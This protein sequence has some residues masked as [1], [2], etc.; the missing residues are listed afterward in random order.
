GKVVPVL[1]TS[2]GHEAT[3]AA[4]LDFLTEFAPSADAPVGFEA[5]DEAGAPVELTSEGPFV[6]T[7]FKVTSDLHVGK[8][9]FL[10]ALRGKLPADGMAW[11][12]ANGQ[13]VK[14]V[15]PARPQGKE[16]QNV[17]GAEAGDILCVTKVEELKLG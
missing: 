6:A 15:H 8:V 3:V 2:S 10:R 14:L 1:F 13:N 7:V 16:L 4:V 11:C 9:C 5:T 12:S 17:T